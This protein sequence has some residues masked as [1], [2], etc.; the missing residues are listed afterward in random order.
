MINAAIVGSSLGSA[1]KYAAPA[2]AA[3]GY[4][5]KAFMNEVME[6][7]SGQ[8]VPGA[9]N[10]IPSTQISGGIESAQA[11]NPQVPNLGAGRS[12]A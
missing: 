11:A 10:L 8:G 9:A 12:L 7:L 6:Q 2:L 5:T 4:D 3:Q 1:M